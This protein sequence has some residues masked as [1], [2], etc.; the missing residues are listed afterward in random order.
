[1]AA[2]LAAAGLAAGFLAAAAGLATVLP[3]LALLTFA[4]SLPASSLIR[5]F[6]FY[7]YYN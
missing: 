6:L 4:F 3:D 1:L 2:G 5:V 7:Y